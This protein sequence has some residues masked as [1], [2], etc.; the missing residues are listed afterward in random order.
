MP[1]ERSQVSENAE[2]EHVHTPESGRDP[3]HALRPGNTSGSGDVEYAQRRASLPPDTPIK[4]GPSREPTANQP[5]PGLEQG[6][7]PAGA[8][9]PPPSGARPRDDDSPPPGLDQ[10][11]LEHSA[12]GPAEPQGESK[13]QLETIQQRNRALVEENAEPGPEGERE[14]GVGQTIASVPSQTGDYSSD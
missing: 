5:Q 10:T 2:G 8:N 9:A 14:T 3:D 1:D 6:D 4:G 11:T 12:P 13:E 7:M